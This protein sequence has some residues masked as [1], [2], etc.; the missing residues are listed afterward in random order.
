MFNQIFLEFFFWI[1][2]DLRQSAKKEEIIFKE[3]F[4]K[5]KISSKKYYFRLSV[6]AS[7]PHTHK[8]TTSWKII[9]LDS[10]SFKAGISQLPGI[11]EFDTIHFLLF[12]KRKWWLNSFSEIG[13]IW[14]VKEKITQVFI[15]RLFP[16]TLLAL[17]QF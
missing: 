3:I 8:Q 4:K 13:V 5:W 14:L 16:P 7:P 1:F 11:P 2:I 15:G 17:F 6:F 9:N 12:S 10:T